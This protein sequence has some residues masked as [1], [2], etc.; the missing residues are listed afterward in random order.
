[1]SNESVIKIVCFQRRLLR[2]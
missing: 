2:S 1:V